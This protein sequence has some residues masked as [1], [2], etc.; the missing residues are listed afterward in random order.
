ML[1]AHIPGGYLFSL[2]GSEEGVYVFWHPLDL[3]TGSHGPIQ[4]LCRSSASGNAEIEVNDQC[5][6]GKGVDKLALK[7]DP[8]QVRQPMTLDQDWRC[9]LKYFS[10][11][12]LREFA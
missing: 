12:F 7:I 2:P 1:R 9:N 3:N 11:P 6:A 10:P 4:V 5:M 8:L